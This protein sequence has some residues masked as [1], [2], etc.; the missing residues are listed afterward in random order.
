MKAAVIDETFFRKAAINVELVWFVALNLELIYWLGPLVCTAGLFQWYKFNRNTKKPGWDWDW[1]QAADISWLDNLF[2][3]PS[4][5]RVEHNRTR[6]QY[7][8]RATGS[9]WG[10]L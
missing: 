7:N 3:R 8:Y 6:D 4:Q 10:I 9:A 1:D 2:S 5:Y